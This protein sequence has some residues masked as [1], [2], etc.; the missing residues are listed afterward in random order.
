MTYR[1]VVRNLTRVA[2]DDIIRALQLYFDV[3]TQQRPRD[4]ETLLMASVLLNEL[5]ARAAAAT[6]MNENDASP[7]GVASIAILRATKED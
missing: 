1:D 2:T 7:N 3:A 4:L 5:T 6:T